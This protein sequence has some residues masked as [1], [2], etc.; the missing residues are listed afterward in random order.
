[1]G[2]RLMQLR[3]KSLGAVFQVSQVRILQGDGR[4]YRKSRLFI[5]SNG[6]Y[7]EISVDILLKIN[8]IKVLEPFY[9][10][11]RWVVREEN[12][13]FHFPLYLSSIVQSLWNLETSF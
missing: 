4:T 5:M 13:N 1:M 7:R 8:F 9:S 12:E 10:F 3:W 2:D 11:G 6:E